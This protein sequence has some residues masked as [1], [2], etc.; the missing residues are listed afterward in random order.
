MGFVEED[1]SGKSNIFAVEPKTLYT[2][3][4]TADRAASS[5]L[6]AL[7]LPIGLG[8]LAILALATLGVAKTD[9]AASLSQAAAGLGNG[10]SLTAIA[11]RIA[12]SL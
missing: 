3:S 7:I 9:P 12:T 1:N 2:S 8:A 10:E 4:P 5:G 6:G 11:A